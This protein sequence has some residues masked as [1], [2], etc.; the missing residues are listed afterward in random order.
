MGF[1]IESRNVKGVRTNFGIFRTHWYPAHMPRA[2]RI[3]ES[4]L[5][6]HI[7]NRRGMRLAIFKKDRDYS[8]FEAVLTQALG[9]PDAPR[10]MF[11]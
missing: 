5:V 4:G 9:R 11:S 8:A 1:P 3:T 7:L 10:R 2:P 6:Y